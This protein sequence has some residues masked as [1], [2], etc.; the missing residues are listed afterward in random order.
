[1]THT[2]PDG[3]LIGEDCRG[4]LRLARSAEQ[5]VL[6]RLPP[7]LSGECANCRGQGRLWFAFLIGLGTRAP[8]GS[9]GTPILYHNGAWFAYDSQQYDCPVCHETGR[10]RLQRLWEGSG[11]TLPERAWKLDYLDG[12]LGKGE[13]VDAAHTLLADLPRPAGWA[14]FFGAFGVG[15]SGLLKSLVAASIHA[16]VPARYVRGLDILSEARGTY[17]DESH[18]SEVDLVSRYARYQFLA[19]DEVDRVSGTEWARA[20]LFTILDDRYNRRD[21]V[22]TALATNAAPGGLDDGMWG[23]LA[24]RMKDGVRVIVSGAD[25]RGERS[26]R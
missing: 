19:V 12:R 4:A 23:Y 26:E 6:L 11:L 10:D 9:P 18:E 3:T 22:A 2:L 8:I 16:G 25:L 17:G 21:S 24:S 5:E 1:M 20:M 15:K 13:S 14:S 7:Q